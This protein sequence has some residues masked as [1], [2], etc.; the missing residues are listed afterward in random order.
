MVVLEWGDGRAVDLMRGEFVIYEP[1]KFSHAIQD[2]ELESLKRM[3]M[4][5]DFDQMTVYLTSM[6]EDPLHRKPEA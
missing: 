3:G 2:D 1:H 5:S 4:V 6:P